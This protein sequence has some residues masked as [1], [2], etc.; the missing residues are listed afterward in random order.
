ML[1]EQLNE[2]PKDKLENVLL[3][4]DGDELQKLLKELLEVLK[5]ELLEELEDELLKVL[6]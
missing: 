4:E 2:V 5:D 6:E 1:L 3:E